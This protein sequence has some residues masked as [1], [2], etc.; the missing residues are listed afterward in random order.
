M[1]IAVFLLTIIPMLA[2]S[3]SLNKHLWK[4]RLLLVV[5]D[6]YENP[7]LVEQHKE[8][9]NKPMAVAD[10]KLIMYQITPSSYQKGIKKS[11]PI[12]NSD[13]YKKFNPSNRDFMV[14][15]I[16]LDGGIKLT[17]N[18]VL[19]SSQIF[20]NIDQMPMRRQGLRNKN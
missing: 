6:S 11:T 9:E 5:A 4:D 7:K 13:F 15:L 19:S 16:G 3:Q 2:L 1:K 10:R 14:I 12:E 18:N 8:F 17:S 20:G